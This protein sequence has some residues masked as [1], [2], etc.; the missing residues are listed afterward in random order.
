MSALALTR[1]ERALARVSKDETPGST[2]FETAQERLLTMRLTT[3][4]NHEQGPRRTHN[5]QSRL[6]RLGA[7]LR[8]Q[9]FRRNPGAGFL[10]HQS[11]QI[12]GRSRR[13]SQADRGAG[14]NPESDR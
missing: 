8:R 7:E 2:W 1:E 5:P 6:C 4:E 3:E 10:L 13:L 12:T 14:D 9:A 11:R